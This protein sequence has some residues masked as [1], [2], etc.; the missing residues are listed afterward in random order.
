[1]K[2]GACYEKKAKYGYMGGGGQQGKRKPVNCYEKGEIWLHGRC[3][4]KGGGEHSISENG[5]PVMK[6]AKYG[7][8]ED[9]KGRGGEQGKRKRV[10]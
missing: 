9:A 8:M 3:E 6:K 1:M 5:L 2:T 4:R 10:T 7:Y